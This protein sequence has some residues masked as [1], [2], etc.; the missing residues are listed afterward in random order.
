MVL[1]PVP[2]LTSP[3]LP[4]TLVLGVLVATTAVPARAQT[5]PD[6]NAKRLRAYH[7]RIVAS[8]RPLSSSASLAELLVPVMTLAAERSPSSSAADEN[9]AALIAMTLVCERLESRDARAGRP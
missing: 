2:R 9:R 6:E 4:A 7:E 8:S 5:T 1:S 3:V